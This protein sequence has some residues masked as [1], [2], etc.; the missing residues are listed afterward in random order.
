MLEPGAGEGCLVAKGQMHDK[1]ANCDKA[2]NYWAPAQRVMPG[3]HLPGWF[4]VPWTSASH[5]LAAHV[6]PHGPCLHGSCCG[7]RS[8]QLSLQSWPRTLSW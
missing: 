4:A 5:V 3:S 1:A 8:R 6:G 2:A 7:Y